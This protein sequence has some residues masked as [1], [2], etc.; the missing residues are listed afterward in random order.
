MSF[1]LDEEE[2]MATLE[3]L[4]AFI[5]CS[6]GLAQPTENGACA[7]ITETSES[8]IVVDEEKSI[9]AL[10]TDMSVQKKTPRRR[11]KRIGWS[12]STGL[13]RR[14]RAQLQFL[15]QHAQNLETYL[16]QLKTCLKPPFVCPTMATRSQWKELATAEFSERLRSEEVNRSLKTIMNSQLEMNKT[17]K[18]VFEE[19]ITSSVDFEG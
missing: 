17:L 3:E 12:S 7:C 13:Q 14:K 2:K 4:F 9:P 8:P 1:L 18:S 10:H 16:Q 15:R 19:G 5:D 6:D 11:R